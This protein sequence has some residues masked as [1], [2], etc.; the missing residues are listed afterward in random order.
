[1]QRGA[2]PSLTGLRGVA[3]LL[4]VFAHFT[5]WTKVNSDPQPW[6]ERWAGAS[7]IGMAIF[8]TLSGYVIAL[9]YSHWDWRNRPAFNLLRLFLYRFARLYPAFFLFAVLAILRSPSIRDLSNPATQ[10]YLAS[11]LLLTY[12]WLPTQYQ[13]LMPQE[14]AFHVAWSL[15]VECGLYLAFGIGAIAVTFLPNSRFKSL[16]IC[17][18]FFI[19]T[20]VL[21]NFAMS[22]RAGL[23]PDWADWKFEHWLYLYSPY[24]VA[25]Q[26]GIGVVAYRISRWTALPAALVNNAGGVSLVAI[27]L[28]SATGAVLDPWNQAM[29]ASFSTALIMVG[30]SSSS[31]VNRML[32]GRAIVYVGTISYSLYLF[33]FLTPAMGFNGSVQAFGASAIS[34]WILNFMAT[35]AMA[36]ILAAG[37]YKLVEAPGRRLIRVAA[38][39]LLGIRRTPIMGERHAAAE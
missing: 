26:F 27:Y 15:S 33:H 38:D 10:E 5:V 3:A 35:A 22:A 2:I 20:Y 13:G 34:Y 39:R 14:G 9:S 16:L 4:I 28:L 36:I 32:S 1:M 29:L 7:G 18:A 11:H 8:F 30:S 37:V 6:L 17:A 25:L 24:G 19:S 21:L 23:A 31:L 12:T